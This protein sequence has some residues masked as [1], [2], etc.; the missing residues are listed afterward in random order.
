MEKE[1]SEER[2]ENKFDQPRKAASSP[3]S[4]AS[5]FGKVGEGVIALHESR[6]F[7]Y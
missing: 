7:V 2:E 5:L 6:K 4:S 3:H 1:R